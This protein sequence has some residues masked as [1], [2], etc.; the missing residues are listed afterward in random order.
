MHYDIYSKRPP[1]EELI[2]YRTMSV[3][4]F[5]KICVKYPDRPLGSRSYNICPHVMRE[6]PRQ[7]G[8]VAICK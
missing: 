2:V 6:P 5:K 8:I 7:N 3:A 1:V 4:S